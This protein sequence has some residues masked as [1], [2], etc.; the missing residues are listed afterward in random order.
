MSRLGSLSL[1]YI[2]L[3]CRQIALIPLRIRV[4]FSF[5]FELFLFLVCFA[6]DA[7]LR[8]VVLCKFFETREKSFR[9]Q[10]SQNK[11]VFVSQDT[12]QYMYY[13]SKTP[14][15]QLLDLLPHV[16]LIPGTRTLYILLI[17]DAV[18]C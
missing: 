7:K 4:L 18:C 1:A 16:L 14:I 10:V 15:N 2:I 11:I 12:L 5:V 6:N 13:R 9:V 17:P 8:T 3:D